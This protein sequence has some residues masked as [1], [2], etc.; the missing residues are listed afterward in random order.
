MRSDYDIIR[1]DSDKDMLVCPIADVHIGALTHME[2]EWDEFC[3]NV[4]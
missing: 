3:R 2:A 1:V 4:K